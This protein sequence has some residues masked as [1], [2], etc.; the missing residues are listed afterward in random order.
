MIKACTRGS[1][2]QTANLIK[3]IRQERFQK[4]DNGLKALE[5]PI[6]VKL[7][8]VSA[9]ECNMIR[10]FFQGALNQFYKLAQVSTCLPCCTVPALHSLVLTSHVQDTSLLCLVVM[11]CRHL[12]TSLLMLAV[13]GRTCGYG[14]PGHSFQCANRAR[15]QATTPTTPQDTEMN[16]LC[17]SVHYFGFCCSRLDQLIGHYS[18]QGQS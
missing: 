16:L 14:C 4:I 15:E 17:I 18:I 1:C 2:L 11:Q 13:D 7:N 8:N 9:M 5:G 10:H 3:D 12:F 6:T